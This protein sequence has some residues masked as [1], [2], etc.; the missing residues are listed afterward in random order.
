M[1]RFV[2]MHLKRK[3][4]KFNEHQA[5]YELLHFILKLK[6]YG[7]AL[8]LLYKVIGEVMCIIIVIADLLLYTSPISSTTASHIVSNSTSALTVSFWYISC[9][10]RRIFSSTI[11][12]LT[13]LQFWTIKINYPDQP[14][15]YIVYKLD[16]IWL[17]FWLNFGDGKKF[18]NF[19]PFNITGCP[20]KVQYS[21]PVRRAKVNFFWTRCIF[22]IN[23]LKV[24]NISPQRCRDIWSD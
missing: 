18:L 10:I 13:Y 11:V 2:V 6:L 23:G 12:T 21:F 22:Q 17:I 24:K 8:M 4:V 16:L 14:G 3:W 20:Q 7:F 19:F 9:T 1:S 15:N 5:W